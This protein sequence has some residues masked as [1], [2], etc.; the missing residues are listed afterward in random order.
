MKSYFTLSIQ[1][2]AI[3]YMVVSLGLITLNPFNFQIFIYTPWVWHL[4]WQDSLQNILLFMP[5]G[6]ILRC[7][8]RQSSFILV[9]YGISLSLSIEFLQM[10]IPERSSNIYDIFFNTMG[11]L[12]GI[13]Y[14]KQLFPNIDQLKF[15][16]LAFLAI[17]ISWVTAMRAVTDIFSAW[18]VIPI[19][20][21]ST[22]AFK[23]VICPYSKQ[24]LGLSAVW[25]I[26]ITLPLVVINLRVGLLAISLM[27]LIF[28]CNGFWNNQISMIKMLSKIG[29]FGI[30][31]AAINWLYQHSPLQWHVATHLC[32]IEVL[33]MTVWVGLMEVKF[34]VQ[35]PI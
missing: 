1:K 27:M 32:W 17:P 20:L 16:L 26:F 22:I 13:L 8:L 9:I 31:F 11:T 21:A 2:I 25:V 19:A 4:D 29:L 35:K 5:L 14:G 34:E 7:T 30:F 23:Q 6:I 10:G 24:N 18:L 15:V 3:I 33:L 28:Y 12:L